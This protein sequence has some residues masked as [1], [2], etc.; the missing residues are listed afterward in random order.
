MGDRPKSS[1]NFWPGEKEARR[2]DDGIG[3]GGGKFSSDI[4]KTGKL[5]YLKV[6]FESDC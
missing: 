6:N 5:V 4:A 2:V 1:E 3:V